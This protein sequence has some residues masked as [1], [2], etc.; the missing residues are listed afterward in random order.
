MPA[1]RPALFCSGKQKFCHKNL[2]YFLLLG[3]FYL[4]MK[5][6]LNAIVNMSVLLHRLSSMIWNICF[7]VCQLGCKNRVSVKC[8]LGQELRHDMPELYQSRSSDISLISVMSHVSIRGSVR[9]LF[10]WSIGPSIA[11]SIGPSVCNL[12]AIKDSK[13][14]MPFIRPCFFKQGR[15]P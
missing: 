4:P 2:H 6:Y 14:L 1:G 10:Y 9:P 15:L 7:L 11:P 12:L 5:H 13:Q 8:S 3:I